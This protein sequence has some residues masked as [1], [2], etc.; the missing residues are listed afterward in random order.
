MELGLPNFTI[1]VKITCENHEGSGKVAIQ[2]W[3]AKTKTWK[4]ITPFYDPI[5]E[6]TDPLVAEDS[7]AYAKENGIPERECS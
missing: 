6:I 7:A 1:P 2:Q 4:I 3:N 5:R